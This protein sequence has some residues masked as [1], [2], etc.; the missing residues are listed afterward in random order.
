MPAHDASFVF[1]ELGAVTLGLAVLARIASRFGFS[2]IPLYLIAGLAFG[3]GGLVPL[4]LSKG[5][6]EL[7]AEIGVLLLLFMLGLEYTGDQLRDNLRRGFPAGVVDFALNFPPGLVA[8]FLLGW[9]PLAA[10]LLG[11]VTYISSSGIIA[12][13]LAELRRLDYPET[14]AVLAILVL[15]DLAMAVYLPV[16]AVL[17]VGGSA[18]STVVSVSVAIVTVAIV[19]S[20]AIRYGRSL[21]RFVSHDSDEII[22]LTTFGTVLLVAGIAQ[23]LQVSAAIGAFLVGIAVSGPMAGQAHRLLA[24]LRDLFAATFFFFFGLQI[25]PATLPPV[26]LFAAGLGLASALTKVLTGYW[27]ARRLGVDRRGGLRAGAALVARGE[28]SI[29]IAGLGA[30]LEPRIGP[31]SAAYVLFLA[32]LGPILTRLIK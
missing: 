7:G 10:V 2:A 31:L 28:F 12:K 25:D 30:A 23:R 11:G 5:F 15:E 27:A 3:N 8:G 18:T 26:L 4:E 6:T 20:V 13:V 17:L 29:V 24:P 21:S 16:V 32:V 9:K 19:L 1:I 14:P 22:L